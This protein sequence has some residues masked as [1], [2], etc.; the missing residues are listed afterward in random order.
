MTG[1]ERVRH[2][3]SC[4]LNIYNT[5]EMTAIEV[6]RL[7]EQREGRLCIRLL[8]RADGTVIT[9][10]CPVGLRAM[11]K[12]LARSV[13]A[14][15]SLIFGLAWTGFAQKDVTSEPRT[16]LTE[17]TK[18]N[19][20]DKETKL[21]GT[22]T[23]PNGGAVAGAELQLYKDKKKDVL[24]STTDVDG[25]YVFSKLSAGTYTLEVKIRGFRTAIHKNIQVVDGFITEVN[26]KLEVFGYQVVGLFAEE[27]LID[28]PSSTVQ[29]T[30]TLRK[31]NRIP[32]K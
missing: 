30:L 27:P 25:K 9:R 13:G 3:N 24:T 21:V 26:L 16:V 2:C 22:V 5:A 28:V 19:D 6:E 17:R 11:R 12:R 29:T 23:D 14:T 7:I 10:D 20:K 1:D 18:T 15:L 32:H 31:I 8:R 4:Q